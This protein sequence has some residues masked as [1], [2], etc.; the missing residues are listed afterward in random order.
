MRPVK[1]TMN[2]P[3]PPSSLGSAPRKVGGFQS[4]LNIF[5]RGVADLDLAEPEPPTAATGELV[6]HARAFQDLRIGDV[7]KP[8]AD[9]V[10]VDRACTFNE[11][12]G[13][14]VEAEHSRMP[15]YRENLDDPV[16]V[17]HVKDVFKLLAR[18]TPQAKARR[19]RALRPPQPSAHGALRPRVDARLGAAGPDARQPHPHGAG[20]RRVRRHRRPR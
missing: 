1:E 14:F 8:R 15:V 12:V 4:L 18:K 17:V 13:R 9:I 7:M 3:D 20:H 19:P 5:R 16:G 11:L 2:D 6:S 10:A